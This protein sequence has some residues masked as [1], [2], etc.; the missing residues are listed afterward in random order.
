MTILNECY[1]HTTAA[2]FYFYEQFDEVRQ[3][4]LILI[5]PFD[6]LSFFVEVVD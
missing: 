4:G 3:Y 2:E 5:K 1:A 6:K